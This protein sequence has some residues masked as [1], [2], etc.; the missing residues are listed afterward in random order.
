M[1]TLQWV[2]TF[3]GLFGLLGFQ[4]ISDPLDFL[5]GVRRAA[6]VHLKIPAEHLFP[7]FQVIDADSDS[8]DAS[9]LVSVFGV[10]APEC[11][12]LVLDEATDS[13][14][15][16]QS[17]H[18]HELVVCSRFHG[19]MPGRAVKANLSATG[20]AP[21]QKLNVSNLLGA[22]PDMTALEV[23]VELEWRA[24]G[25]SLFPPLNGGHQEW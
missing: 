20:A 14:E 22:G 25:F 18:T 9:Q 3:M 2:V 19:E 6:G 5:F 17:I 16:L 11:G 24:S 15:P 4:Q 21:K 1:T 10:F 13:G 12:N 7:A 8:V 23:G